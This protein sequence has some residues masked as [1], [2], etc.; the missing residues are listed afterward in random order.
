M[1]YR[2]SR[3][4]DDENCLRQVM[5]VPGALGAALVDHGNGLVVRFTGR[6]PSEDQQ[7]TGAGVAG[8]VDAT[9]GSAAFANLGS[10]GHLDDIVVTAGNGYH[11]VHFPGGRHD[12]RLVL[13]LWLDRP[14]GNLAMAQRAMRS[15][16]DEL[17][18]H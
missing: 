16:G 1:F 9:L 11:L 7:T 15:A 2:E 17:I 8:L 10:P 6:V 3:V 18:A 12:L 5:G 4:F 14:R 13:Y